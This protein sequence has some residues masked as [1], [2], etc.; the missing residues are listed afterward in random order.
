MKPHAQFVLAVAGLL[1]ATAPVRAVTVFF[2]FSA[3]N[4]VE[5]NAFNVPVRLSATTNRDVTVSYART[6]GTANNNLTLGQQDYI[7]AIGTVTIKA[8]TLGTNF[9]VTT[10]HPAALDENDET[11]ILA[12]SAPVN[13]TLGSPSTCTLTLNDHP[14]DGPPTLSWSGSIGGAESTTAPAVTLSANSGKAVTVSYSVTGGTATGGADYSVGATTLNILPES[15]GTNIPLTIINDTSDEDSETIDFTMVSAGNANLPGVSS[16]DRTYTIS[17]NDNPPT[18]SFSAAGGSGGENVNGSVNL[19]VSVPSGKTISGDLAVSGT[20]RPGNPNRDFTLS[21]STF[22]LPPGVAGTNVT[23]QVV[24]DSR[25]EPNETVVL[26]LQ[27]VLNATE[28]GPST[29][30]YTINDNDDPP[31]VAFVD[32]AAGE[33]E[34]NA[35]VVLVQLSQTSDLAPAVDYAVIGGTASNGVDYVLA[36]GTLVFG[37]TNATLPLPLTLTD[38]GLAEPGETLL[39]QLSNPTNCTLGALATNRFTIRDTGANL[40]APVLA[41]TL[42]PTNTALITW[43]SHLTGFS[44]QENTNLATT[45]WGDPAEAVHD[46]GTNKSILVNPPTGTGFYR[47][48]KP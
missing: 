43:P 23:L 16:R 34:T 40:P 38:D 48:F 15:G 7:S 12:L 10:L 6:G 29:Y 35:P 11:I 42:T 5:G 30:T 19:N 14:S 2:G 46:D 25:D 26:N 1:L 18:I 13:A 32:N 4:V 20:A 47:L 36:A 9:F 28:T 17:D 24:N 27:S 41:I 31:A 21:L 33:S 39:L 37:P 3:T 22:T 45:N 44:L 8:N